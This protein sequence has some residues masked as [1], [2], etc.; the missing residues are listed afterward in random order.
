MTSAPDDSFLLLDKDT[1]WFLVYAKIEPQISFSTIKNF[2]SWANW[3]PQYQLVNI[4]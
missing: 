1:N 3:N 4:K 2:T